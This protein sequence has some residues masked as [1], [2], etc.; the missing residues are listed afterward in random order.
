[1]YRAV[2]GSSAIQSAVESSCSGNIRKL[3]IATVVLSA[4]Q[5][6]I[7]QA[8][9]GNRWGTTAEGGSRKAGCGGKSAEASPVPM[10][11]NNTAHA[12]G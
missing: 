11:G 5:L 6:A 12:E 9:G 8:G 2:A 1:M 10:D 3:L 4:T 7:A